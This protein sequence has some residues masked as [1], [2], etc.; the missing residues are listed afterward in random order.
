MMKNSCLKLMTL[1]PLVFA[2]CSP[3][4]SSNAA[5]TAIKT[6]VPPLEITA[7]ATLPVATPLNSEISP[8]NTPGG[9]A[10]QRPAGWELYQDGD[11][12]ILLAYPTGWVVGEQ[13]SEIV[14]QG[15][16]ADRI[17]L[18][19]VD[20]GGLSLQE[21]LDQ[22]QLPNTRCTNGTN[23]FGVAFQSCFDTLAFST[24]VFLV[25]SPPQGNT[26]LF[27]LSTFQRGSQDILEEMT[28]SFQP[29]Q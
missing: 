29:L 13:G 18:E 12:R 27:S 16:G 28:A 6:T 19:K 4:T 14:F 5:P 2:G 7:A 8:T 20:A 9:Q 22:N 3:I 24:T 23:P 26:Q 17:S 10:Y 15:P 21:F 1:L 11:L 25:I